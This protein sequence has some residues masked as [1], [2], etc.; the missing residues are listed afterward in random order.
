MRVTDKLI[1]SVTDVGNSRFQKSVYRV[2]CAPQAEGAIIHDAPET[3][4]V[5]WRW[6]TGVHVY[7]VGH[8]LHRVVSAA[9][10]AAPL[11]NCFVIRHTRTL[12][13]A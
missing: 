10:G 7:L 6:M 13:A 2:H 8:L 5:A 4:S 12:A 9:A 11:R 3:L 1:I